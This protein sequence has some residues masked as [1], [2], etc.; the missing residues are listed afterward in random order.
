VPDGDLA[1]VIDGL[2]S[3][4]RR[5]LLAANPHLALYLES[6]GLNPEFKLATQGINHEQ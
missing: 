6:R 1:A 2:P 3:E 5:S 4:K